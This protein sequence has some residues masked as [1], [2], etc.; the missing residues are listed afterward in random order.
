MKIVSFSLWGDDPK[1][2][3]GAI[4]NAEL[5]PEIYPGWICKFY[6][7][8]TV[9]YEISDQLEQMDH[10]RVIHMSEPGD[11]TSMF[12]R[13]Y[14]AFFDD[15]DAFISRDCDSR[16]TEREALAV[17]EWLSGPKLIHVMRDHPEHST[18][19]MGGMWGAKQGALPNLEEQIEEYVRG[20]FWQVDQNFLR[21]I[22]WPA[23]YHKVLA[24]DD[25][26]RFPQAETKR[27]PSSRVADDFVGS[28]IGANNERLH[29]EHHN[30]FSC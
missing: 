4:R 24:H 7:G 13:F 17:N 26:N 1:Y 29:P 11:W 3:L 10:V 5:A 19:I 8:Y 12:W 20:D 16:I 6:V 15:I 2:C 22:V 28:I 14:P 30:V 9:P 23:N 18:P 25:W 21:E 27:F